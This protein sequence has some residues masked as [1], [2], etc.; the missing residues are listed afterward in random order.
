MPDPTYNKLIDLAH[1]DRY[2]GKIKDWVGP[3]FA[4]VAVGEDEVVAEAK[5]DALELTAGTNVTISVN[6]STGAITFSATDTTYSAA[7]DE[8]AGL[9]SASDKSKLDGIAS[10]A[11]VGTIT[12]ITT[13]S[14]LSGSGTSGSVA[15]SH[16]DSGV[17]AASKGDTS[18]QTPGFGGEF[19]VLSGTVNATGHL[20]AFADHNV[21]IPSDTA[22]ASTSGVGGTAGLMSPVDKEKLDGVAAGATANEGTVTSVAGSTGLTGTVTSSGS[23]KPDLVS[24]TPLIYAASA[25]TTTEGR[26]YPVALDSNNKLAVNVPW[27]NTDSVTG[28]KGDS[29]SSYRTG[30]V[31]ITAANIGLG[32]V[33]NTSDAN[34]P[35]STAMQTALDG[36]LGTGLKGAANGLAELDSSG[37]VPES[38]LP[39]WM[40]DVVDG[41]LDGTHFYEDAE[42]TTPLEQDQE[43]G[44]IFVDVSTNIVYRWSGTAYVSLSSGL[45]LGTNHST[46]YYGDYGA[47]AYAHGVTNKGSQYASGFYKITTNAEG[48]VTAAT[49]VQKS[50]VTSLGIPESDTTYSA[51][52]GL[53]LNSS[54]EFSLATTGTGQGTSGSTVAQT[55]TF[56]GTFDVPYVSTD[57]YGRVSARGTATVTVPS[58]TATASASGAGGSAGLMSAT[59]KEKLDGIPANPGIYFATCATA[60][61]TATKVATLA[62]D[63]GFTLTAGT[64]VA[65]M[66]RYGN[67]A[68]IPR[69][70]VDGVNTGT[71]TDKPMAV[72]TAESSFTSGNGTGIG[73]WGA[74]ETLIFAYNGTYWV[75]GPS[76]RAVFQGMTWG[77]VANQTDSVPLTAQ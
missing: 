3:N 25:A 64:V 27:V 32:N 41:Y 19:K 47:A 42:H 8:A 7:T 10:G 9:M 40:D 4:I 24:E 26:V 43:S 33:D 71:G 29:E 48:H 18:N 15:L 36:K 31:N 5:G 62:C 56:G 1:L 17:T 73:T 20:T 66:F 52:T 14:P 53:V 13:T 46:A 12:G 50:D 54:D 16:A 75:H 74:Y 39:S 57:G 58:T 60:A 11:D 23:I 65:V 30:N 69:L 22:T 55:P 37:K 59:D 28:V 35:V 70:R 72:A 45:A 63:T 44:I 51:G 67:S 6:E 2:D 76:A 77:Q 68:D 38:Q 21:T 61:S 49:A 34:K